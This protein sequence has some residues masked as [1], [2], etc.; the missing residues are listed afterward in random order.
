MPGAP[1]LNI[2]DPSNWPVGPTRFCL[3]GGPG[4]GKSTA[5]GD[6]YG[7]LKRA[8]RR[9]EV[10][11]E[12]IK[13]FAYRGLVPTPADR[14]RFFSDG[15]AAE[16][17]YA[18]LGLD[19]VTDSPLWLDCYYIREDAHPLLAQLEAVARRMDELFGTLHVFMVRRHSYD[20]VGRYQ[21]EA[22]AIEVDRRMKDYLTEKGVTF[23][24]GYAD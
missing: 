9:A 15:W 8:K 20:P 1:V 11:P 14:V 12:R 17:A 2:L 10:V 7:A 23:I 13:E 3:Y 18:N 24:E 19:V 16:L 21:D 6:L 5:F 4:A 22:A